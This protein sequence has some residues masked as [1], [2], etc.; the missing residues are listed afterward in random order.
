[1]ALPQVVD[2]VVGSYLDEVDAQV[3]GLIEGLY[4][5]GSVA[6]GDF[7]RGGPVARFGPSGAS[8]SDLDFVA[9]TAQ[10][11][12]PPE[13]AALARAH[14]RLT[15]RHRRPTFDGLYL[16]W[17]DLARDPADVLAGAHVHDGRL[18][19]AQ[20]A[21]THPVIWHELAQHGLTIRGPEPAQLQVRTDRAGLTAWVRANLDSYWRRW[22]RASSRPLS[23]HGV[24]CLSSWGPTWGV[25]GVSRLH[26]TL[27]TG[28]ICSK[29]A[30]GHYARDRFDPR[31]HRLVDECLRIRCGLP[32]RSAYATPAARRRDALDFVD[33]VISDAHRMDSGDPA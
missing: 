30:G 15:R 13:L 32:G 23:G 2:D 22:H 4:L 24:V 28:L 19:R 12:G 11:P 8:V 10:P 25:L 17:P 9:V 21:H 33:M 1:M 29:T 27:T 31:W 6:M 18:H 5:I 14:G 3:R 16:T 26:Y 20:P 7:R